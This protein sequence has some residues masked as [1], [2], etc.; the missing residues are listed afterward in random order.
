M[1]AIPLLV[2][3]LILATAAAAADERV[4][5]DMP[6]PMVSHMLGN[7]RDHITALNEI[8]TALA[9]RDFERAAEVAEHRLGI[10]SLAQHGADHMAAYMPKA[11][12]AIG[13]DMHRSATRFARAA[14][15]RDLDKSLAE[16]AAITRQC[17]ACHAA[18]RVH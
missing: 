14:Q 13:T 3:G 5:V 4:R 18:Y 2:T 9:T 7:M 8:H 11:M 15:E 17:V 16:L 1:R 12:Q 6:A 10:S